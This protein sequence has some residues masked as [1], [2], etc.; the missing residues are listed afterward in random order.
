MTLLNMASAMVA[1]WVRAD[2]GMAARI[3]IGQLRENQKPTM[4]GLELG[5]VSDD[6]HVLFLQGGASLQ[7][8]MVPMNLLPA[9]RMQPVTSLRVKSVIA[10]VVE[11]SA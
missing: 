6:Y 11:A 8:S 5:G 3:L 2:P 10:S 9:D 1:G 7:F 4:A